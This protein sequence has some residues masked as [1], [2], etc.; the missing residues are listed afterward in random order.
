MRKYVVIVF[1]LMFFLHPIT[2][3][4]LANSGPVYWEGEPGH[5]I[6]SVE[7]NSPIIV[8]KEELTFDLAD[9]NAIDGKVTALY[10]M[11]NPTSEL[12]E[13]AM[14]FPYIGNLLYLTQ[15]NITIIA[16]GKMIDYQMFIGDRLDSGDKEELFHFDNIVHSISGEVYEGEH[17]TNNQVGNLY[18]IKPI[19]PTDNTITVDV[20]FDLE[21]DSEETYFI[22]NGFYSYGWYNNSI[23]LSTRYTGEDIELFVIG[24]EDINLNIHAYIDNKEDIVDYE[25]FTQQKEI[26]DILQNLID[27]RTQDFDDMISQEQ[28]YNLYASALDNDLF[29]YG[30]SSEQDLFEEAYLQRLILLKYIVEFPPNQLQEVSVTYEITGEMDRTETVDPLYTYEYIFN[31]ANNWH[32]F[33]QLSIFITTPDHSPFIVNSSIDLVKLEDNIYTTSVEGLPAED[34]FFTLYSKEEVIKNEGPSRSMIAPLLNYSVPILG[35]FSILVI[36]AIITRR[37]KRHQ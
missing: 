34:L 31:P 25:V 12:L 13:V 30:H 24:E 23:E 9:D 10:E 15:D 37:L 21:S 29:I 18:T 35:I 26:R 16:N 36:G 2:S 6:L 33:H 27:K 11:Y 32:D 19:G 8:Q 28:L 4:I 5:S 14:V 17:F 20:N 3:V 22:S 7:K 1:M